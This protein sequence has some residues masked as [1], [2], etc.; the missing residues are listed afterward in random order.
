MRV[1]G[2][3]PGLVKT[4]WGVIEVSGT[5]VTH[6]AN[7]VLKAGGKNLPSRLADL[8]GLLSDILA[9]FVP[10]TA[11]VEQTFVNASGASSLKLA[12]ARAIALLVPA[13]FGL[14]VS[15]YAPNAVKKTVVGVGHAQKQQVAH[16][17]QS[18][19]PGVKIHGED[20]FDALAI[21]ICHAHNARFAGRLDAA[22]IRAERARA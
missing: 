8:H 16:M 7:G 22:V 21:A 2:I 18:Q 6:V 17:V 3:D 4:G 19:F 15:E 9:R 5:K 14:N 1:I 20:A 11:G 10:E 13:Q 12:Q